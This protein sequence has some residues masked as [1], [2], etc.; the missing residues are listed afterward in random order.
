MRFRFLSPLSVAFRSLGPILKGEARRGERIGLAPYLGLIPGRPLRAPLQ[1]SLL[2]PTFYA[3]IIVI[4]KSRSMC[5][6][7]CGPVHK[8]YRPR[9]PKGG[10][11]IMIALPRFNGILSAKGYA[12][13]VTAITPCFAEQAIIG[14]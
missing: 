8:R 2:T 4:E 9:V 11:K 3:W 7:C 12:R 1:R 5:R 10:S 14:E 13:S 6:D